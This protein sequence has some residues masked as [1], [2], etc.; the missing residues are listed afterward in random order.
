MGPAVAQR[1]VRREKAVVVAFEFERDARRGDRKIG[2]G[3]ILVPRGSVDGVTD[4][5]I[6]RASATIAHGS[7]QTNFRDFI[8]VRGIGDLDGGIVVTSWI[9]IVRFHQW[10]IT[11]RE[12]LMAILATK[13]T[14]RHNT[15]R[16]RA[17][18]RGTAGPTRPFPPIRPRI[19]RMPLNSRCPCSTCCPA[20]LNVFIHG[21][22][23]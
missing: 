5:S 14:V 2:H 13:S 12:L 20:Y 15:P 21:R 23:R 18:A 8:R 17:V 4:H 11:Y 9:P 22:K 3:L 6:F 1:P 19:T 7:A 10:V 16:F